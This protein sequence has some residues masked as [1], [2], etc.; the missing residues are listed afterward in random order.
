MLIKDTYYFSG[1]D[2]IEAPQEFLSF[3]LGK[4]KK[5]ILSNFE[6]IIFDIKACDRYIST[7]RYKINFLTIVTNKT[8]SHVQSFKV[9]VLSLNKIH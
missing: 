7:I 9:K 8:K 4:R 5:M 6:R 1:Y 3:F 2:L